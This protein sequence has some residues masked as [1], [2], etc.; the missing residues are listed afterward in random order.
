MHGKRIKSPPATVATNIF[1]QREPK[2]VRIAAV[3]A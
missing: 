3:T 2:Q 1:V